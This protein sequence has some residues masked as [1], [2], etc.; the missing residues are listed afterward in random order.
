MSTASPSLFPL[1]SLIRGS[2]TV[3]VA[4]SICIVSPLTRRSPVT[5]KSF[6]TVK[7]PSAGP[8]LAKLLNCVIDA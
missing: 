4:V 8:T 3:K 7:V 6:V 1:A 2:S 5:V